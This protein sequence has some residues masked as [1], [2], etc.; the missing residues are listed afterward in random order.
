MTARLCAAGALAFLRAVAP[1]VAL[2]VAAAPAASANEPSLCGIFSY[3]NS[4]QGVASFGTVAFDGAGKATIDLRVNA[5]SHT[6]SR[7]TRV[8]SA[9]GAYTFGT[10]MMGEMAFDLSEAGIENARY[11][12][13]VTTM[14]NG[15]P[16][17]MVTVLE[18]GG[19][20]GQLVMAEL[21]RLSGCAS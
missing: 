14:A 11:D 9:E 21:K 18:P 6:G 5:Q 8:L 2:L 3:V 7:T 12:L 13:V 4:N 20:N 10:N 1:A 15:A 17:T 19:I 16:S